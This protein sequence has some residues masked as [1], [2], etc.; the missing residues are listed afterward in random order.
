M[1]LYLN[2]CHVDVVKYALED[3]LY[4]YEL[5]IVTT[6]QAENAK[7]VLKR[8]SMLEREKEGRR[9]ELLRQCK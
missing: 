5:G 3:V 2:P 6:E 4:A 7:V 9:N 8:I 1:R